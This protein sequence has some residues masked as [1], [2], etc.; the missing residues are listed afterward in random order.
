MYVGVD[1]HKRVAVYAAVDGSG[2]VV[3][4]GR[5]ENTLEGWKAFAEIVGPGSEVAL[6]ATLNWGRVHDLLESLGLRPVVANS[7]RV[8]MIAESRNKNDRIDSEVLAQLLRTDFLPRVHVPRKE[9]RQKRELLSYRVSLGRSLRRMKSQVHALLMKEWVDAPHELFSNEGKA[10]LRC[11][12]LPPLKRATLDGLLAQLETLEGEVARCQ[13][14]LAQLSLEDDDVRRLMEIRGIDYYSAQIVVS[15]VD[16][17]RRFSNW[18]KLA[19]YAG[20]VPS[21]RSSAEKAYHGHITKAGPSILRWILVENVPYVVQANPQLAHAHQRIAR[22][23][24]RGVAR[25]AVAR[26]LV[27]II[28]HMLR[29][30]THYR[31]VTEKTYRRKLSEMAV[32][33]RRFEPKREVG[34]RS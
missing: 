9:V 4:R 34:A 16:D 13:S 5:V 25:V 19:A 17:V 1:L 2:K 28:Y 12:E 14:L 11:V 30:G 18:R 26:R 7:K 15:W 31:Y 6:E 8:R 10:F 29:D 27:R 20:L 21:N 3:S 33:A 32:D 22:R 24:G 23:R